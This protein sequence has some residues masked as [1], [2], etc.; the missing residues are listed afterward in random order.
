M[1]LRFASEVRRRAILHFAVLALL[2]AFAAIAAQA[3]TSCTVS[4]A[5]DSGSGTNGTGPG[6]PGDLR[7]CINYVDSNGGSG[8]SSIN[9]DTTVFRSSNTVSQNTIPLSGSL[10]AITANVTITGPTGGSGSTLQV[11][12]VG[13]TLWRRDITVNSGATLTIDNLNM[14]IAGGSSM[15]AAEARSGT[16]GGR[17][18]GY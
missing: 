2:A 4:L 16:T 10:P 1:Y 15:P 9:F 3:Q 11:V 14:M 18:N 7:Y 13:G 8:S 17:V 5:T 6:Y 12:T